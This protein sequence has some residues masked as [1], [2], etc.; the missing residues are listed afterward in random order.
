MKKVSLLVLVCMI[1]SLMLATL[2]A[3]GENHTHK[4]GAEYVFDKTNHFKLC[5]CGEKMESAKHADANNDEACD[6]CGY[7][8]NHTVHT[9]GADWAFD[10]TN[11]YNVCDE[12]KATSN[13]A[14]HAD[15]N[16]DG[17]CDTCA[18]IMDNEHVFDTAW[19]SDATDH[20]NAP[21][22]GHDVEVKNKAAHTPDAIGNCS[23]CGYN[24]SAPDVST[25]EKA[26]AIAAFTQSSVKNGTLYTISNATSEYAYAISTSYEFGDKYFH[27][28][29]EADDRNVYV[30][31]N[32]DGSVFYL[33]LEPNNTMRPVFVDENADET[34][35]EGP[36][37]DVA[38]L[39]SNSIEFYGPI[40]LLDFFYTT[41]VDGLE[42]VEVTESVEDGV[43]SFTYVTVEGGPVVSV[44]FTLAPDTYILDSLT[45]LVDDNGYAN[46][47][48]FEQQIEPVNN[49]KPEQVIPV[50]YD[51]VDEAGTPIVFENG[52]CAPINA[53]IGA[54]YHITFANIVPSTAIIDA[55]GISNSITFTDTEGNGFASAYGTYQDGVITI[56]I[57]K[58]GTYNAHITVAGE[59]LTIP[60]V[61]SYKTPTSDSITLNTYTDQNGNTPANS[62]TIFVGGSVMF[63]AEFADGCKQ[64]AYTAT[65]TSDNADKATISNLG[66]DIYPNLTYS[67][68]ATEAGTYVITIV[69][70]ENPEATA[71]YTVTV[72]NAPT[73]NEIA[74]GKHEYLGSMATYT[75][76]FYPA[77]S[78][79]TSGMLIVNYTPKFYGQPG[80]ESYNY[81]IDD[82]VFTATV[83]ENTLTAVSSV[84]IGGNYQV[85][86]GSYAC[87]QISETPDTLPGQEGG[88]EGGSEVVATPIN[89]GSANTPETLM[90]ESTGTVAY[91]T[92]IDSEGWFNIYD[93]G[94]DEGDWTL[95]FSF[96]GDVTAVVYDADGEEVADTTNMVFNYE[97]GNE[98][99]VKFVNT[100]GAPVEVVITLVVA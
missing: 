38:N 23:V 31:L 96:T 57:Y 95:N 79:N 30:T 76:N 40:Q 47:V 94:M 26:I 81:T 87:T 69:A 92:T 20:W 28:Y 13:V 39:I 44:A 55:I 52:V 91:K 19:T 27:S 46:A 68:T 89:P 54:A 16:N 25:V 14:A 78:E 18:V 60:F 83:V 74:V 65:V 77:N 63:N 80:S 10:A 15:T 21:L 49:Y 70:D 93:Y 51:I 34:Y 84:T 24:V 59:E 5:S 33:V 73:A 43:Y 53:G 17:A 11:H 6:A 22:C 9:Y 7:A 36:M 29:N 56:T 48:A 8:M 82:G 75:V 88:G 4:A 37:V 71:E 32:D 61:V 3:C 72:K 2:T 42:N 90:I 41:Y 86:V 64:N 62:A 97:T 50:D 1:L 58:E 85:M 12:C 67:F 98:Y 66:S 99:Q 45:I 100:T 35:M